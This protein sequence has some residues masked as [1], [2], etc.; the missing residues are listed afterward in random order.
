MKADDFITIFKKAER[1][2]L[3]YAEVY[4]RK[5]EENSEEDIIKTYNKAAKFGRRAFNLLEKKLYG[6]LT[7]KNF[8]R[9]IESGN[10]RI[11]EGDNIYNIYRRKEDGLK[12]VFAYKPVFLPLELFA[13]RYPKQISDEWG[14]GKSIY[15]PAL[16]HKLGLKCENIDPFSTLKNLESKSEVKNDTRK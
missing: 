6:F 13:K 14:E 2:L 4:D 10:V 16:E 5:R 8:Y 11:D 3:Y 12:I 15:D 1:R 9:Q 7:E